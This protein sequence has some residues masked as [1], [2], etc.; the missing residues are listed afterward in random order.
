MS[1][2]AVIIKASEINNK[3]MWNVLPY[4]K[5][6]RLSTVRQADRILVVD[7][8][9]IVEQGSHGQLVKKNG[10]YAKLHSMQHGGL[11]VV[12]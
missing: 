12:S 5:I 7:K 8:G 4:P 2:S 9:H 10:V 11:R 6:Y 3:P 1:S